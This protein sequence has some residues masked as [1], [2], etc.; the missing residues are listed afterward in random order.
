MQW[1]YCVLALQGALVQRVLCPLLFTLQLLITV[2]DNEN[3]IL[4]QQNMKSH[5]IAYTWLRTPVDAQMVADISH[6]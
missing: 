3:I 6:M 4:D 5:M 2:Q 1:V